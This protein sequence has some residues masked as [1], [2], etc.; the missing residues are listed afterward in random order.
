MT[1]ADAPT[2]IGDARWPGTLRPYQRDVLERLRNRF[3][4]G[5]PRAWV[6]LPPGAGK[7][8]VGL[9]AA[10]ELGARTVVL[11][12]NTAIQGQ[13]VAEWERFERPGGAR[14]GTSRELTDAVN[15]LT[16]QSLA[17]FDPDADADAGTDSRTTTHPDSRTD[18]QPETET[19]ARSDVPPGTPPV[20]QS[21]GRRL[22]GRL[23]PNGAALVEA[24]RGAGPL[25]IVL[26]ECHHL[27]QV[28]GRLLA[29]ILAEL[30]ARAHV[31]GLTGTPPTTLTRT[32]S[33]LVTGLFGAPV[34][35]ASIPA[36]VRDG[37]LAP[38]AELAWLA[39][40]TA[41]ERDY[42]AENGLRFSEL[43][44]D[45]LAPGFAEPDFRS[46]LHTRF[47]EGVDPD[48]GERRSWPESAAAE[49]DLADALLRLHHAGHVPPPE[50][51]RLHERHRTAPSVADWMALL[52]DYA[53][54]HL[55]PGP[56]R[57]AAN[58][59]AFERV[60]AALPAVGYQLT[61]RGV[62]TGRSPVDR[63][64]ARSAAKARATVEIAA[65]ESAAMGDELRALVLCDHEREGARPSAR[66][67]GVLADEAGSAWECL[68]LLGEDVRTRPLR[69]MLVT[70]RTVATTAEVAA[71]FIAW[72][73]RRRPGLELAAVSG[74][75][76]TV[77]G[78]GAR[79]ADL[80][81]VEGEWGSRTWVRLATAYFTEGGCQVLV[82][83]R[84]MLGEGWDAPAVN[85]VIDLTTATTPTA[86]VQGRGRAL[87]LDPERPGKT[88]HTWT[89]VCVSPD[90][91]QGAGDWERFVR[92]HE[93][94]LAVDPEGEVMNGVAHVDPTF[95][96]FH[97]PPA[98]AFDAVNARMLARAEDRLGTRER[99]RVG[100]PYRDE[101]LPTLRVSPLP[102][103][104]PEWTRSVPEDAEVR[105]P[106]AVPAQWGIAMRD[107]DPADRPSQ[108]PT[109]ASAV[110]GALAAACVALFC[111]ALG[112][113]TGAVVAAP[114]ALAAVERLVVR[115]ARLAAATRL[116]REAA[117]PPGVVAFARA[118]ADALAATGQSEAG[119]E[120]VRLHVDRDGSYRVTLTGAGP[121][122][123]ERFRA[124]LDEVLSPV[125]GTPRR[126]I[127]R[128]EVAPEGHP[129]GERGLAA[130]WLRYE[131]PY[132]RVAAHAVPAV[133]AR[134][135]ARLAAFEQAWRRWVSAGVSVSG[136]LAAQ[137]PA[138]RAEPGAA[139]P[140]PVATTSRLTWW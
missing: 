127:A 65:V 87:R 9:E 20:P 64:L 56:G 5:E 25:T 95:S 29:E 93:G 8:L 66:L 57:P 52:N 135:H 13:W 77:L 2:V 4:S 99:W 122:A 81:R 90:H 42:L 14:A 133:F 45:L 73:R 21:P 33:A 140:V 115:R 19:D 32:E 131:A 58:A 97:P 61:R 110:L 126:L 63:V 70:G 26:D 107:A 104:A 41:V 44:T 103:A 119:A 80:V 94:Y 50:G 71:D 114:A 43:C 53:R 7:T 48:T 72:V 106:G 12:P 67:R 27:L 51:A 54:R 16:Y 113:I 101:V 83:T 116:V 10:R 31:I 39:A 47:V 130:A 75:A 137:A 84:G 46:W 76:D 40:P 109:P 96:P 128:Y 85:T 88:A 55:L 89:V 62:R 74:G 15:V 86:V 68:V 139:T 6:V 23:H 123:A 132:N 120:G 112:L 1:A 38:F 134:D 117:R 36:L 125:T 124:A 79:E 98:E 22:L 69:P 136:A 11:V 102:G 18:T 3:A 59:E 105:P 37:Y 111:L 118:V 49:P 34:H 138:L 91:P 35:G 60:R 28:W 78:I 17:V 30:D 121:E 82:G 108:A 129:G 24:L 92:K 100:T